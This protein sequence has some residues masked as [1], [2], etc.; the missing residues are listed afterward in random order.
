MHGMKSLK[1][2]N[3]FKHVYEKGITGL[4]KFLVIRAVENNLDISRFGFS[5]NKKLG[6]AVTRNRIKRLLKESTRS[7]KIKNGLDIIYI[8]R[9]DSARADFRQIRSS[10]ENI[11]GRL[12][13]L[14][15]ENE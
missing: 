14:Q 5:V 12:G 7:L 9:T 4:D 8:A 15:D 1:N 6:R 2:R 11:L 3:D 13:L 10:S